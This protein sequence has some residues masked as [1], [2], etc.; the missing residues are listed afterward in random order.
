MVLKLIEL[1]SRFKLEEMKKI[2]R[3]TIQ[4]LRLSAFIY[5]KIV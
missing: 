4:N 5:Q 1:D 3:G 2:D